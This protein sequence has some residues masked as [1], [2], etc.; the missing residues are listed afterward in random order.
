M[1]TTTPALLNLNV[2]KK[3]KVA[4]RSARRA[5]WP[6]GRGVAPPPWISLRGWACLLASAAQR[7]AQ[8][9]RLGGEMVCGCRRIDLLVAQRLDLGDVRA[10]LIAGVGGAVSG[11]VLLDAGQLC[12]QGI[13]GPA[14]HV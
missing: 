4:A 9:L 5:A 1:P 6:W 11:E 8:R 13:P 10:E 3:L 14:G 7:R 2:H 12:Q